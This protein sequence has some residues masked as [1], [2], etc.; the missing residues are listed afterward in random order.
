MPKQPGKR[1]RKRGRSSSGLESSDPF[2][3]RRSFAGRDRCPGL[4][5]WCFA[6]EA[7]QRS[8]LKIP[9]GKTCEGLEHPRRKE[10][11]AR[12]TSRCLLP[13]RTWSNWPALLRDQSPLALVRVSLP[14]DLLAQVK[15]G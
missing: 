8:F 15:T 12:W 14:D 2:V 6:Q 7:G 1:G 13:S 9:V 11:A 4:F 3:T 5:A 10:W